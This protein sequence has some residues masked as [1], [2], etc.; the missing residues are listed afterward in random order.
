VTAGSLLIVAG[1]N[2]GS[3]SPGVSDTLGTSYSL[4][5]SASPS[6]NEYLVVYAGIAPSSGANTVTI[7]GE[8]SYPGIAILE[9]V[10]ATTSVDATAVSTPYKIT[11][12]VTDDFVFVYA[13][14]QHSGQTFSPP[15]GYFLGGSAN[16]NDSCAWAFVVLPYIGNTLAALI[17]LGDASSQ[18][19]AVAFKT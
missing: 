2:Y 9:V 15:A 1:D 19:V 6:D 5:A 3:D 17:D 18:Q 12:T 11:T 13:G 14:S 8:T 16:N 10:G 4:V 7:S